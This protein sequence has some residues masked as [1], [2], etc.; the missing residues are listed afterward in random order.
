MTNFDKEI[1]E[2]TEINEFNQ[3]VVDECVFDTNGVIT[4]DDELL[5]DKYNDFYFSKYR[6][7]DRGVRLTEAF[8]APNFI[9]LFN[10]RHRLC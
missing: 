4:P 2:Y 3:Y 10:E 5:Y 8:R 7:F 6:I 9:L 1:I